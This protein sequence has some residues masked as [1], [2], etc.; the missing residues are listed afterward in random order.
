VSAADA[1][2]FVRVVAAMLLPW[3]LREAPRRWW[4]PVV[5]FVIAAASDFFDGIVAR[6]GRGPTAHGAVLD[7]SADVAFVLSGTGTGASWGL[8]SRAVPAA[9]VVAFAAYAAASL[10]L[11]ARAGEGR[12]A[13]SAIGHA[14]GVLNYVLTGLVVGAVA[15]PARAWT[16]L[17]AVGSAA[18]VAANGGA[19]L[20]RLVAPL[21]RR[22]RA[23]RDAGSRA[24]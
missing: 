8:V 5:L 3:A 23:P 22:A 12:L 10:R 6:R 15:L 16:P 18:V 19:V 11:S 13:R 14:A 21:L 24:R 1:L 2:G 9:I 17:L 20:A 4:P 7:N